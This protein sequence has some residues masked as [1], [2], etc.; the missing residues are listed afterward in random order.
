MIEF[1][2]GFGILCGYFHRG[3]QVW[4]DGGCRKFEVKRAR[5]STRNDVECFV[6]CIQSLY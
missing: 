6:S 1:L 3:V 2:Q 4:C 5:H